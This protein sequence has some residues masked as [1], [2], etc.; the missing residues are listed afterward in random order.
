MLVGGKDGVRALTV[1]VVM[2]L[3]SLVAV[4]AATA[5][6]SAPTAKGYQLRACV[7]KKTKAVRIVVVPKKCTKRERAVRINTTVTQPTPAI[8]Y[9]VGAPTPALG[10][11]GDFYVDTANYVFYGPRVAGNWG[12]GQSLGGRPDQRGL[13]DL[14]GRRV[15]AGLPALPVLRVQRDRLVGSVHT[16]VSST[17]WMRRW[18][19]LQ[20]PYR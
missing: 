14:L 2:V 15:L 1:A 7:H 6:P 9:G 18:S 8:R 3:A 5:A 12:V 17:P 19:Q 10:V 13:L 20:R 16:A 11:D 4:P